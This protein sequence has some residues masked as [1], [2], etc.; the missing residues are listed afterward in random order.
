MIK[1]LFF[2]LSLMQNEAQGMTL[3]EMEKILL[4]SNLQIKAQEAEV[5]LNF[6]KV[7][8]IKSKKYIPKFEFVFLT[9][10]IPEA[11][12]DILHP[13]DK[14]GDIEGLGPFFKV[15]VE[16]YQPIYTFGRFSYAEESAQFLGKSSSEKLEVTKNE[17]L[18]RLR[19]VYLS[20]LLSSELYDFTLELED[21]Y[22]K[23]YDKA[24]ST[25]EKGG[26]I[27]ETDILKLEMFGENLK[28]QKSELELS[29]KNLI[30]TIRLLLSSDSILPRTVSL[31]F[32][33]FENK[34]LDFYI[35]SAIEKRPEIKAL[36]SV[37]DA[38][39]AKIKAI[40]AKYF[41]VFFFG[42]TFGYGYAPNRTPQTNP[43]ANEEFN[44]KVLGAALGIKEDLDFHHTI[45][46]VEEAK[47]ELNKTEAELTALKSGIRLEVKTAYQNVESIMAKLKSSETAYLKSKSLFLSTLLN[48]E[49]GLV[50]VKDVL[51]NFK[52]YIE[53]RTEYLKTLFTYDKAVIELF[54]SA[55]IP[56]EFPGI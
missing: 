42:G 33:N 41:P 37:I 3:Q 9:G 26:E 32:I 23:V 39:K 29:R 51:D 36:T 13:E 56:S 12:G 34:G 48:Y 30:E 43:W 19:I 4:S 38:L 24:K 45:K 18:K 16:L 1:I 40:K 47:A 20:Y 46:E 49:M 2:F 6:A 27:T 8:N 10:P 35:E 15:K 17:L 44:Y 5:S 50:E 21:A 54:H 25:L 55:G 14:V 53:A 52:D 31:P 7:E 11:K 22:N 28:A